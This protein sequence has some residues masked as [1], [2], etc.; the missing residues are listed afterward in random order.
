MTREFSI[1]SDDDHH[2]PH[3]KNTAVM[4]FSDGG[5]LDPIADIVVTGKEEHDG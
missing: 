3:Q 5:L 2:N 4:I 1:Q